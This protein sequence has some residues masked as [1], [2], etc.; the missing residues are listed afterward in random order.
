MTGI[1]MAS[2][3][4]LSLA[5]WPL[6]STRH[7]LVFSA[8]PVAGAS[9]LLCALHPPLAVGRSMRSCKS[10]SPSK[11]WRGL[12]GRVRSHRSSTRTRMKL[13]GAAAAF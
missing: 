3:A 7:S 11:L 9:F 8:E 6:A 1:L 2:C 4:S 5:A 12:S 10:Q 13:R